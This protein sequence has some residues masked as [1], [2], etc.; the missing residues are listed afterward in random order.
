[1]AQGFAFDGQSLITP[2][3]IIRPNDHQNLPSSDQLILAKAELA[4]ALDLCLQQFQSGVDPHAIIRRVTETLHQLRRRFHA[5][6]WDEIVPLVQAHPVTDFVFQ[7][8]FTKWSFD[9]PRG[10]SGD[11]HLLDFIYGHSEVEGEIAAATELG[12]KIYDY[13]KDASSS[14]AVRE[15]RDLLARRVDDIASKHDD[16]IEVLAVASGHLR[17]ASLSI[18]LREGRIKRWV[19]LDQD[20]LSVG[21]VT[22]DFA[23]TPVEAINGSVKTLISGRHKLG[24]LDFVYAAGLYDYLADGVAVKLT[25][26]CLQMVKPGGSFLFANF[27]QATRVD[28]YMETFMNWPLLLRTEDD[29]QSIAE[30]ATGTDDVSISVWSGENLDVIYCEIKKL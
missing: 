1:M 5:R 26:R 21:T 9:K 3:Q 29:M 8:P 27:S 24:T 7:D 14:V 20:P 13:T 2:G 25:K 23:G 15:R 17:E 16:Q 30:N 18:A 6:I 28:G 4:I 12:R 22:R 10:Y 11:A 19:A